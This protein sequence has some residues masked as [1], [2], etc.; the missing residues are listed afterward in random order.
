M[1]RR[2]LVETPTAALTLM[3][4]STTVPSVEKLLQT[5]TMDQTVLDM[6]LL[7][8]VLQLLQGKNKGRLVVLLRA[9]IQ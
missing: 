3:V 4:E 2:V 6:S 7:I 5:M 9:L 1:A 8:S